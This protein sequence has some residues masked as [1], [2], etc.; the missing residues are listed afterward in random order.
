[1]YK[2][3]NFV[4]IKIFTRCREK[5]NRPGRTGNGPDGF[6]GPEANDEVEAEVEVVRP[7]IWPG[8]AAFLFCPPFG[9]IALFFWYQ[10]VQNIITGF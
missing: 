3:F 10:T 8:I 1:M 4:G 5:K 6:D 9:M 7:R 2:K